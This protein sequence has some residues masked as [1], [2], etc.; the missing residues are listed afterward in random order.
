MA[1][2][3]KV[4]SSD[5]MCRPLKLETE[6]DEKIFS[7]GIIIP[8]SLCMLLSY[9]V[10]NQVSIMSDQTKLLPYRSPIKDVEFKGPIFFTI[11]YLST[12]YVGKSYMKNQKEFKIKP[13]IFVYNLYQCVFN[14]IT[15]TLMLR[16]VY[17]NPWF[18]GQLWGNYEQKDINGFRIEVLVWIHYNNKFAELLDSLWMILRKKDNQLSFLHCYHHGLLKFNIDIIMMNIFL[19]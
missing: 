6:D 3:N 11:L 8:L 9:Y 13:Y 19:N 10:W 17:T 18:K 4:E 16:E 12:L 7:T 5:D 1:S 15:V 2:L 14:I